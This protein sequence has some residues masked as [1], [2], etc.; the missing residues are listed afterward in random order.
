MS[1]SSC[2]RFRCSFKAAPSVAWIVPTESR[3]TF[4]KKCRTF[5][6]LDSQQTPKYGRAN[7]FSQT[8]FSEP[9]LDGEPF[10]NISQQLHNHRNKPFQVVSIDDLVDQPCYQL[11]KVDFHFR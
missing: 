11:F 1:T 5:A 7:I 10:P 8:A 3:K 9:N 2:N 4:E 6:K